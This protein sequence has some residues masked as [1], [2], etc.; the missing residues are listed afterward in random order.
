MVKNKQAELSVLIMAGGSGTRLWPLSRN[1]FPKQFL[2]LENE[3][4]L[5][6][7][8]LERIEELNPK[9][10]FVICN[11]DHRFLVAQELQDSRQSDKIKIIL[12]PVGRNTAPAVGFAALCTDPSD[13]LLVLPSDHLIQDKLQFLETV[14]KAFVLAE[15]GKLITFGVV[16]TD[17]NT[18]YGY[19]KKGASF[20]SGFQ[21]DEFVE[22]PELNKA[23]EYHDSGEYLWNSG[24]FLFQAE[25]YLS[26]LTENWEFIINY[27]PHCLFHI[28]KT[29][30]SQMNHI[31]LVKYCQNILNEA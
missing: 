15:K 27:F 12:E 28:R 10:I 31:Q 1:S 19:I 14:G 9:S 5:L 18:G 7:L 23:I 26:E 25:T 11:Y 17:A 30:V 29:T 2:E 16:P 3:K 20:L 22:K 8:T 24:I 6:K 4:S 13:K 21:I